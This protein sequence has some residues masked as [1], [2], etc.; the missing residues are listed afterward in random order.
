MGAGIDIEGR[1]GQ[2]QWKAPVERDLD[3]DPRNRNLVGEEGYA[4][5]NLVPMF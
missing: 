5:P 3:S 1:P 4:G 2:I